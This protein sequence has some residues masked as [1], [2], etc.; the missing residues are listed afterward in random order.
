MI[1]Q[2]KT[3]VRRA[4][5]PNRASI[6]KFFLIVF[7]LTTQFALAQSPRVKTANVDAKGAESSDEAV[8]ETQA[9]SRAPGS[10]SRSR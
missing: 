3:R 7:T 9:Q 2:V 1:D 8:G 4:G 5:S 6:A 10:G